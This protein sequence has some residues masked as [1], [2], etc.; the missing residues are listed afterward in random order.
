MI[1]NVN[2][3]T[4]TDV[5]GFAVDTGGATIN[6]INNDAAGAATVTNLGANF[7]ANT[8]NAAYEARIYCDPN[9][10]TI[11]YSLE[12]LDVAQLVEGSVNADIPAAATLLSPQVWCNNGAVAGPVA[13]GL[14]T[15]YIETFN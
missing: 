12:R 13:L 5:L 7:P 9:S 11:F 15:Q 14:S 1:G 6:W 3:S 8:A 2:P 4:L 10:G